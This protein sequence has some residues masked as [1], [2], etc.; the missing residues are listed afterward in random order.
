[1]RAGDGKI[2]SDTQVMATD[3]G[4]AGVRATAEKAA[5]RL[6]ALDISA[7]LSSAGE[8]ANSLLASARGESSSGSAPARPASSSGRTGCGTT[9]STS[10]GPP[11]TPEQRAG[12]FRA[13]LQQD[14]VPL[15]K[16]CSTVF[17]EGVPDIG[18]SG[19]LRAITW[20]LALGYLPP[21]HSEW[22]P[23]LATQRALYREFV[24]ELTTDPRER[25]ETRTSN[26][27]LTSIE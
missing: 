22:E 18:G 1:M 27:I 8:R 20:K 6:A 10:T 26:L 2:T 4:L 23:H 17:A 19:E 13:L 9:S 12:R 25:S 3:R 14:P 5:S 7:A 21:E 16:L 24:R 11:L 15:R